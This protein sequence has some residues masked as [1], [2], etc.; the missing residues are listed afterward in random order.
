MLEESVNRASVAAI[1][2]T[3][4]NS[5]VYLHGV[6]GQFGNIA[7][8]ALFVSVS[9][10]HAFNL[11]R[12][13]SVPRRAVHAIGKNQRVV[14]LSSVATAKVNVCHI[15]GALLLQVSSNISPTRAYASLV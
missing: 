5:V 7:T 3:G 4:G 8:N 14:M 1:D 10:V 15:G 12:S 11:N 13:V 9:S 6:I 2:D